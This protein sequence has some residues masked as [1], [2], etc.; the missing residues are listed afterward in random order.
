VLVARRTRPLG[1]E[2]V[3]AVRALAGA[4]VVVWFVRGVQILVA[5]YSTGDPT[6]AAFQNPTGFKVVHL[7]LG[8]V[9]VALAL[10]SLRVASREAAGRDL[11]QDGAPR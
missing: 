5:D 7:L 9:A 1:D 4:T 3:A 8:A 10:L 6:S 2:G 11:R